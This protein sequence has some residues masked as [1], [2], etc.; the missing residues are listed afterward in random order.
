MRLSNRTW[1]QIAVGVALVLRI[2]AFAWAIA[3]P[4][5]NESGEPVSPLLVQPG[6]DYNFY[7]ATRQRIFQYDLGSVAADFTAFFG[8][9][10]DGLRMFVSAP[11]LPVLL[12]AFDYGAGNTLPLSVFFLLISGALVVLWLAWLHRAGVPGPWLLLF[13]ALPNPIWMTLSISTDLL[14]ALCFAAFYL[15]YFHGKGRRTFWIAGTVAVVATMAR[16]NGLVVPFFMLVHQVLV[17]VPRGRLLSFGLV[18]G[19]GVTAA[20]AL[21][22]LPQFLVFLRASMKIRYFGLTQADY[23]NGVIAWLPAWI[24][25]PL[26]W[27]ALGGAKILYFCGLRPSYG[28]VPLFLVLARAAPGLVLLPGLVYAFLRGDNA[29]R[30]LLA[31]YLFPVLAGATQDRYNLAIQPLLFY[32]GVASLMALAGSPLVHRLLPAPF[33]SPQPPRT[34]LRSG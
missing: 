16:P 19:A 9:A 22:Y 32:F 11:L 5:P 20:L 12:Q 21:Y 10:A 14:F 3:E 28:D 15:L 29:H 24:D 17:R 33:A 31:I 1:F 26:S 25:R 4:I 23:L 8:G 2:L 7:E 27:L 13:A 18:I 6:A 34:A 30:L